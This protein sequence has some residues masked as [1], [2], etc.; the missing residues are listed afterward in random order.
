MQTLNL[1]K[2]R[3]PYEVELK[4]KG[5][6]RTFK[7]PNELTIEESERLMEAEIQLKELA[8]QEVND[9]TDEEKKLDQYF[10]VLYQY[11]LI[12]FNKHQPEIEKVEH[13]KQMM[14]QQEAVSVLEFFKKKRFLHLLGLDDD[15]SEFKKK[16]QKQPNSNLKN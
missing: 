1:Y 13:V 16:S 15:E 4:L 14:T 6:L 5:K 9:K 7:I 8:K 10:K 11:L 3:Q 2:D 12:L